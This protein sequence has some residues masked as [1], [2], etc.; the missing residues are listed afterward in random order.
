MFTKLG[1][2]SLLRYTEKR[3][4]YYLS[5]L[6]HWNRFLKSVESFSSSFRTSARERAKIVALSPP[7]QHSLVKSRSLVML[8]GIGEKG[9]GRTTLKPLH[10]EGTRFH[11]VIKNFMTQSGDFSRGAGTGGESIYRGMFKGK[12]KK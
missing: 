3:F 11:R 1:S 6:M 9:D 12:F 4:C 8:E 2:F 5:Y 7:V 10:Y